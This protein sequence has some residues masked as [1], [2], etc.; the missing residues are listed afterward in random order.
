MKSVWLM[1][2][3][4]LVSS[5]AW[6]K[7]TAEGDKVRVLE[8]Q[9]VSSC[10]SLGSVTV[11]LL[12]KVAGVKRNQQKVEKELK[13]LARNN[14]VGLGGDT[15]V[16]DSGIKDGEQTFKVYRCVGV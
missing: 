11:S 3:C 8:P 14:A 6:V 12:D 4:V 10:K 5:C 15:V 1:A 16:P 7:L 2:F 13:I 9:E